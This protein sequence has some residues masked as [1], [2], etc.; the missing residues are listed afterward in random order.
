MKNEASVIALRIVAAMIDI[1]IAMAVFAGFT[2]YITPLFENTTGDLNLIEFV[3]LV[4]VG[5]LIPFLYFII[6]TWLFGRTLG[7]FIC[8]LT[9]Y[10]DDN[11][12][13]TFLGSLGREMVKLIS[14]SFQIGAVIGFV[15]LCMGNNTFWDSLANSD[16][17]Y[18]RG[19]SE[20]QR[21]CRKT[22]R[23]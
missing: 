10:R 11:K 19:L 21:N 18:T 15:Q 14:W 16:V 5:F 22:Y 3:L 8:G 20:T 9:V 7:K 1:P 6:P 23:R 4:P 2:N 12:R 13:L 17:V